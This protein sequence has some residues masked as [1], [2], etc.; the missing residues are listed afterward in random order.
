[1]TKSKDGSAGPPLEREVKARVDPDAV[2][3]L[4][5]AVA[6]TT[7]VALPPQRLVATYFDTA[8]LQ[9]IRW[10]ITLRHR[11]GEG[12][13]AWTLKLPAASGDVIERAELRFAGPVGQPPAGA[14]AIL[15]AVLQGQS[16]QPVCV[17]KTQ[18]RRAQIVGADGGPIAEIDDD[19]VVGSRDGEIVT[20][21]REIEVELQPGAAPESTKSIVKRLT[22]SGADLS[23]SA[24]K[25]AAVLGV[26]ATAAPDVASPALT[27]KATTGEVVR[28]AVSRA[29]ERLLLHDPWL[30]CS[31]EPEHVHQAR[32]A[33]RRLRSD[34][35]T[36]G[37][38]VDRAWRAA[39]NEDLRWLAGLLGEVRDLDVRLPRLK[40]AVL[41]LA[42]GDRQSA[43]P[44]V[45]HTVQLRTQARTTLNEALRSERYLTLVGRLVAASKVAPAAGPADGPAAAAGLR[46]QL[47]ANARRITKR[48]RRLGKRPSDAA[49]HRI[50]IEAKRVRYAAELAT[51]VLGRAIAGVAPAAA[52]VQTVLGDLHDAVVNV[53]RLREYMGDAGGAEAYAAGLLV[54]AELKL[55][56][57][58]RK[59]W[60][61][62]WKKLKRAL[63]QANLA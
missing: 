51:P 18:R 21:F 55:I 22:A 13:N 31:E 28:S 34:L 44:I 19:L 59:E 3:D 11:T 29:T 26:A 52:D 27:K 1:M 41:N 5:D 46:G 2:V 30:R 37:P 53:E 48:V 40:A 47:R 62:P 14:M 9:L 4:T 8:D 39:N 49:L 16:L 33:T 12:R 38:M 43:E 45:A 50:R 60:R 35:R 24:P 61:G 7:I 54:A 20:Q 57:A 63:E 15:V 23:S 17:I 56:R 36:L 6:G 25:L 58:T 32:V 10:G 42:P